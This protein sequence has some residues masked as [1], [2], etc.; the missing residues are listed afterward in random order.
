M[1]NAD[2][3]PGGRSYPEPSLLIDGRWEAGEGRPGDV[4]DVVDPATEERLAPVPAASTGQVEAATTAA[5]RSFRCLV[6]AL[7]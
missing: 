1:E 6:R 7:R 3:A 4:A 2:S 5:A